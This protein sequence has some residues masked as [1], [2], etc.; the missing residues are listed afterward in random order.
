MPPP[1]PE[2]RLPADAETL[3]SAISGGLL[4]DATHTKYDS[5]VMGKRGWVEICK[6]RD[7]DPLAVSAGTERRFPILLLE[8]R[9]PV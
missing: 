3:L 7:L 1:L 8:N 9:L 5:F 2:G 6:A 4:Y